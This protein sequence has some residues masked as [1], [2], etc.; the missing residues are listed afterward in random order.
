MNERLMFYVAECMEFTM[1]GEYIEDIETIEEAI[2]I[3]NSIPDE[4]LNGGKGIGF[5]IY[6]DSKFKSSFDLL[7]NDEIDVDTINSISEFRNDV[8]VQNAIKN[9]SKYFPDKVTKS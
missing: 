4:R 1:L 9:I 3:Y 8:L 5:I 7:I 6:Q 2:N